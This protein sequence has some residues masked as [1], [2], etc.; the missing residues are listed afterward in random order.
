VK[1]GGGGGTIGTLLTGGTGGSEGGEAEG[2]INLA[3][4]DKVMITIGAGGLPQSN[5]EAGNV[6]AGGS[7]SF[8]IYL[9]A[10]GAPITNALSS[11]PGGKGIGGAITRSGMPGGHA[12]VISNALD[13]TGGNGGGHGGGP[14]Y[15]AASQHAPGVSLDATT[16][17]AGG[18]G[19][20]V[21]KDAPATY[22]AGA[23]APGA[24]YIYW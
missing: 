22:K 19:Y 1:G 15:A 24:V 20:V 18:A 6:T 14:G 12:T 2:I 5:V 13:R 16:P 7:S 21:Y 23:G 4:I 9:T 17:G 11:Q 3:G 10:T 8:G